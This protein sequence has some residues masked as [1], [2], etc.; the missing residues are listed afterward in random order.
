MNP[1]A[2]KG[3]IKVGEGRGFIIQYSRE[4][5]PFRGKRSCLNVRLVITAAHCL[6]H[7]PPCHPASYLEERTYPH[8]LGPLRGAKP[9]VWTECVFVDPVA[10]IALLGSP[11]NQELGDESESYD[12]LMEEALPFAIGKA[13]QLLEMEQHAWVLTLD[14][15][16]RQCVIKS[17]GPAI[18]LQDRYRVVKG[19]MSGSPIV[20]ENGAAIGVL[21]TGTLCEGNPI[22]EG[23]Y[24]PSLEHNLPVWAW[25]KSLKLHAEKRSQPAKGRGN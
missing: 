23:A 5:P 14:C 10:D 4:S 15:N 20:H 1:T 22:K 24:N 21:S 16:W 17:L 2:T 18:L 19:G 9:N 7:L 8:L 3:V 6:P 13:G 25:R 11:D 12:A